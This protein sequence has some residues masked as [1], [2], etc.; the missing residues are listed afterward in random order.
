MKILHPGF[1]HKWICV[2]V[3]NATHSFFKAILAP[4]LLRL[5]KDYKYTR[6]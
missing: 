4:A 3:A 6:M 2:A 1:Q 5:H